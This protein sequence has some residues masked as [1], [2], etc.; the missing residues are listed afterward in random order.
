MNAMPKDNHGIVSLGAD[1]VLRSICPNLTVLSYEKL[2]NN[3]IQKL[4]D[5]YGRD[6]NLSKAFE[7]VDG[8]DVVDQE[9]LTRGDKDFL[10]A[11]LRE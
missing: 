8:H 3:Q 5:S 10:P 9:Q 2:N 6:D 7:G 4:V 11:A 1:G